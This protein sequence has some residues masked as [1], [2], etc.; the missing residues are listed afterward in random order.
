MIKILS[1]RLLIAFFISSCST[2]FSQEIIPYDSPLLLDLKTNNCGYNC[3]VFAASDLKLKVSPTALKERLGLDDQL[4]NSLS[5][6]TLQ[7]VFSEMHVGSVVLGGLEAW[8]RGQACF[9]FH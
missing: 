4:F 1:F 6:E 2:G 3:A 9:R 5:L 7:K 8:K